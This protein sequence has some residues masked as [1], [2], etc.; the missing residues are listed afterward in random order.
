[1]VTLCPQKRRRSHPG[2]TVLCE[3][4]A[5]EHQQHGEEIIERQ[6]L[7]KYH[8]APSGSGRNSSSELVSEPASLVELRKKSG[9]SEPDDLKEQH[10]ER[11]IDQS[12]QYGRDHARLEAL[13]HPGLT[14]NEHE[15]QQH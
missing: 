11:R 7:M 10:Q 4:H 1:M 2:A 14:S 9:S 12:R 15:R 13:R 8:F 6:M 5:D 3:K